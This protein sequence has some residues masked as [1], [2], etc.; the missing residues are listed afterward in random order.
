MLIV[1][2]VLVFILS[3][4]LLFL[5]LRIVALLLLYLEEPICYMKLENSTGFQEEL[6][7]YY[8]E[9]DID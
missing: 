9:T 7:E 6:E 3:I 2:L 4:V 8:E 5:A 1:K